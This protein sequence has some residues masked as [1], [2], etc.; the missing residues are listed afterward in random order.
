M[1]IAVISDIHANLAALDEVLGDI[2]RRGVDLTVNLGDCC[3]APLWPRETFER[4][5]S[6]KLPTVR[7]N[8]DRWIATV[9]YD[10]LGRA[11]QY[12]Y[13]QLLPEQRKALGALPPTIQ[14]DDVLAVH[15]TP[16]D[17][18]T[19][20]IE[21]RIE[22]RFVVAPMTLVGERLGDVRSSLV[23][24]GHSHNQQMLQV[25]GGPLILNPGSIGCPVFA[26]SPDACRWDVRTPHAR[27]AIA[28]RMKDQWSVELFA[29]AYD[30][31]RAA[32]RA[33]EN[34]RSEWAQ[35][36]RTGSALN[37]TGGVSHAQ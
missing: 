27:Y 15:G 1:R 13:D 9:A 11:G 20:L 4:L 3:A 28:S 5:D 26:D 12:E 2:G 35:A 7:G 6:L 19:Y 31:E 33:L 32:R 24:C 23:L 16:H 34:G 36:Y 18:A 29:L 22:H 17:D 14:L 37:A 21:Q 30:W 8:H 10:K 25:P